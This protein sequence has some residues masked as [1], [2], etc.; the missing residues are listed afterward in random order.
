MQ[1][2]SLTCILLLA[3]GLVAVSRSQ[4]K[5]TKITRGPDPGFVGEVSYTGVPDSGSVL[6][7]T[8]RFTIP[9]DS[10][11]AVR[12]DSL[13]SVFENNPTNRYL[14]SDL[15]RPDS[16][17]IRPAVG[18]EIVGPEVWSEQIIPGQEY[19]FTTTVRLKSQYQSQ[20]YFAVASRYGRQVLGTVTFFPGKIPH[21]I[22]YVTNIVVDSLGHY[23]HYHSAVKDSTVKGFRPFDSTGA[24]P[25]D[26]SF[27]KNG[28]VLGVVQKIDDIRSLHF[29]HP[30]PRVKGQLPK[31]LKR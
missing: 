2:R 7:V 10:L 31:W 6:E 25:P 17:Y 24:P 11:G 18:V 12:F 16:V 13:R 15:E 3:V 8:C 21:V 4:T 5:A 19:V 28:K 26:T 20:A 23:W 27:D 1:P 29:S 22:G 14:K 9:P 30:F